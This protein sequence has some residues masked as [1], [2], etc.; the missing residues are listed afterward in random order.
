[1]NKKQI[2]VIIP[3]YNRAGTLERAITS[4]FQQTL[5]PKEL[6]VVDDGSTDETPQLLDRLGEAFT[7]KV[8]RLQNSGVS[9]ARNKGVEQSTGEWMAFLDSDD[10][11]LPHKLERQWECI[12]ENPSLSVFHTDEFWVRNGK[13]VPV[14]VKYSKS[15][16]DIFKKSLAVCAMCPSSVLIRKELFKSLG[17]FDVHFPVCE[18]YDLWLKITARVLVGFVNEPLVVKYGGHADQLSQQRGMDWYR[19]LSLARLLDEEILS[20]EQKKAAQEVLITKCDIL[21]KGFHKS[22]NMKDYDFVFSLR[23]KWSENQC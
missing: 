7:F 19:I 3:T 13:S 8:I 11:W 10:E 22:G 21:I 14:P 1:M 20:D 4:V 15:G 18:D 12:L 16:G 23:Q 2:S 6:I 5:A 17:G 9:A